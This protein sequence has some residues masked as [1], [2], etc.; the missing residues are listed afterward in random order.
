MKITLKLKTSPISI[1]SAYYKRNMAFNEN[2][3]KWRANFLK[4]L[5]DKKYI[6]KFEKFRHM[7]NPKKHM[8]RVSF[9]WFQPVEVLFTKQGQLSLRST[10]VDNC[11]KI[12]TDC[13]FDAKYNEKWLSLRKGGEAKLY[14]DFTGL[15]NLNINDKFIFDTRSIKLPSEDSDYHCLIE[16]EMVDLPSHSFL[17]NAQK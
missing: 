7:F 13:L 9:T 2:T 10:D 17:R 16:V 4:Q 14:K 12:P 1:N 3:R 6:E 8:L 15:Q 11:L 5:Q